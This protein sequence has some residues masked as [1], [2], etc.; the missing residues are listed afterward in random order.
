MFGRRKRQER[1]I[2][3]RGR[4]ARATIVDARQA[5]DGLWDLRLHVTPESDTPFEATARAATPQGDTPALGSQVDVMHEPGNRSRAVVAG[6]LPTAGTPGPGRNPRAPRGGDQA[7]HDLVSGILERFG[8][9]GSA[10][11]NP[12]GG[13]G[14]PDIVVDATT[15][16]FVNGQRVTPTPSA[17]VDRLTN[18]ELKQMAQRDPAGMV[19]EILRR[20][21]T[22]EMVPMN[23]ETNVQEVNVDG[24]AAAQAV[25][26]LRQSGLLSDDQTAQIR[27]HLG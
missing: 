25:D 14:N 8:V 4:P 5:G 10:A 18:E 2:R 1:R 17:G 21:S 9:D 26:A 27:K 3:Q 7:A 20:L 11:G 6:T 19:H 22:G 13:P 24:E 15:E 12:G 16:V 23:V